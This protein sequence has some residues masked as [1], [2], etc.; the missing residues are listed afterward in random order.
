MFD[1]VFLGTSASAPS[2]QRG[3]SAT[4]ISYK[5]HRF[6]IDCGEGTQRQILSS[7]LG[8]KRLNKILVTHDHLDHILGLGGLTSTL[9]RWEAID[10]I[11][12]Y[13]GQRTLDRIKQLLFQVVFPGQ[14]GPVN[15]ELTALKQGPIFENRTFKLTCFPVFHRGTDSFGFI[16]TE[17]SRRRFLNDKAESLGVP[18]GP[19]RRL[20]VSGQAITLADGRVIEP[21]QVLGPEIAGT[22]IAYVGDTGR[23]DN[24]VEHV[25]GADL[26]VIEATYLDQDADMAGRFS[27]LT[28]RQAAQLAIE[29]EVKQL[30]LNHISRRYW[31]QD[32]LD[33]ARSVF[34]NSHVARDLEHVEISRK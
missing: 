30:Y 4:M 22:K 20:L 28:A 10:Q 13:G 31:E 15:I 27:H 26:L 24:L 2:V 14:R 1:L 9:S 11:T 3:L 6:L 25:R 33:E 18:I 34:P 16:F 12:I 21:E 32:I 23:T 17:K 19:E 5:E 29:A 8:F 7:G